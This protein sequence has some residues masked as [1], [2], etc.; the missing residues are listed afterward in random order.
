MKLTLLGIRHHGVGSARY[1]QE[2]LSQIRPDLLLVEGPPELDTV[3]THL[4]SNELQPPVAVLAYNPD[5]LKQA[6]Y[7]PF[8]T[9]SPEWQALTWA[10]QQDVPTRMIDL[11]VSHSFGIEQ[12]K[13]AVAEN[14]EDRKVGET[15]ETTETTT[16]D[17]P[18][19]KS[20]Q[21][22]SLLSLAQA[23]GYDDSEAWWEQ[24]VEQRYVKE[25]ALDHFDAVQ[26][27]M[28]AL[29]EY[30]APNAENDL[31][32]A[33]MRQLIRQAE[34]DGFGNVVV[35]CGAWH[36]PGLTTWSTTKKEDTRLLKGLPKTTVR[37]TWIPW[38][39]DRL[40]WRSGYG[41]GITSP[42]W[43]DHN[44]NHPDDTGI[45]W[46]THVARLFR[47]N[48]MDTSTAHVIEAYRL[49][50]TLAGLRN[51]PRAGLSELNEATTTVLCFGDSILLKLVEE[52]LIVGKKMGQVPADT[53]KLPLQ[54]DF[55][56]LTRKIRLPQSAERKDYELDL[57]KDLDLNRSRLLH[58]LTILEVTWG[59]RGAA[60][61]KGTFKE[62]WTLRW[63]PD[64]VLQ[65]IEKA[66]FGNNVE[67]AATAFLLDKSGRTNRIGDLAQ[68]MQ[69]AIPAE[70]FGAIEQLLARIGE[71]ATVSADVL[72]LMQAFT[73]LVDV[74][75]YGNVRNTDLTV[76]HQLIEGLI[77]RVCIGLP[78]ACYGLDNDSAALMLKQIRLV[79]EATRLLENESLR[80]L[81][82][83]TL[84]QLLLK[85]EHLN[86][87][88]SAPGINPL[89]T[90]GLC[91]IL[92]DGQLLSLSETTTAFGLA[93]SASQ[94]ATASA[95]WLEGFLSG[96]GLILLY[97]QVLWNLLYKWVADLPAEHF[98]E[99]LPILRRTFA[100]FE[101]ADRRQ[102]GT[103]ARQGISA[104]V[105]TSSKEVT[106]FNTERA[107]QV[108]GVMNELLGL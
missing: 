48:K 20:S 4:A 104:S 103:K 106:A 59:T 66:I 3:L 28:T 84:H 49:A 15:P 51:L 29:R 68:L 77:T 40:G 57:R 92:F 9:F 17:E 105:V 25:Y 5:D 88:T 61:T 14:T 80:I 79:N 21:T 45:R 108:L 69:Q 91:R 89:I 72:E 43:Y 94:P 86:T 52:E 46:L 33:Y 98:S 8:A 65:L 58:R 107:S 36:V 100:R 13:K 1:V 73:P 22:T 78:N 11:P 24:H 102:L 67:N 19:D 12:R 63:Q 101:P 55:E 37:A 26:Q 85:A 62:V 56:E 34:T 87:D 35:V 50:E 71:L 32:E 60:R 44:W 96:S 90:G 97:D 64:M 53:P 74:S 47:K 23:D 70:L 10:V 30:A 42:G 41:A 6:V 31:R 39:Y 2:A 16:L 75:R 38:T 82:N 83:T 81:W 7:Y 27:A 95:A 18:S 54:A 99:L 76:I 93:L